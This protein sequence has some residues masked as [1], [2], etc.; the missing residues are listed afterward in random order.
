MKNIMR[1]M[2]DGLII[3]LATIGLGQFAWSQGQI[4]IT[5]LTGTELVNVQKGPTFTAI[6][7]A[8]LANYVGNG[9]LTTLNIP[10]TATGK[11]LKWN[12]TADLLDLRGQSKFIYR[13]TSSG[14]GT[15]VKTEFSGTAAEHN[16]FE[17]TADWTANG[18]TGGGVRAISGLA[19]VDSTYSLGST[20][21]LLGVRGI[22]Q[23]SGT[24]S[25]TGNHAALY[26]LIETDQAWTAVGHLAGIWIDSHLAATPGSGNFS[27]AYMSNNGAATFGQAFYIYGGDKVTNLL[28]LD[29][30]SGM[31]STTTTGIPSGTIQKIQ[32][33]INGTPYYLVASTAPG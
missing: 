29:T 15:Q 19:R 28:A 3:V 21:N 17:S 13:P 22:V 4:I 9:G 33:L 24:V 23:N 18:T 27:M 11:F 12:V 25:G 1:K 26:G 6:T 7:A 14:F 8:N 10:G 5:T 2:R 20:A 16:A 30:V 32:I 31:V